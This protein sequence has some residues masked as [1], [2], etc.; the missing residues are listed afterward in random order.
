MIAAVERGP[1]YGWYH[2]SVSLS[3]FVFAFLFV[4][5]FVFV[6]ICSKKRT[7]VAMVGCREVLGMVGITRPCL[8]LYL[9]LHFCLFLYLYLSVFAPRRGPW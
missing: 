2:P 6:C 4:S 7:L 5:V 9:Y 3:V 8:C 1:R